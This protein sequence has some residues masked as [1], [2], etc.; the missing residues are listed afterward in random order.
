MFENWTVKVVGH[1]GK[2]LNKVRIRT[3]D[4]VITVPDS[5]HRALVIELLDLEGVNTL[6]LNYA[7]PLI[8]AVNKEILT[9]HLG[10]MGLIDLT[11]KVTIVSKEVRLPWKV[12]KPIVM[13]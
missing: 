10:E 3:V 11:S 9:R 5:R 8:K 4:S 7:Y 12:A 13:G 2:Y 1:N 6:Q